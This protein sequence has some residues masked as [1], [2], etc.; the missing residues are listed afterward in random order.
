MWRGQASHPGGV[1]NAS[2]CFMLQKP[3]KALASGSV[4]CLWLECISPPSTNPTTTTD[5]SILIITTPPPLD[6]IFLRGYKAWGGGGGTPYNRLYREPLPERGSLFSLE[7]YK[8]VTCNQALFFQ[9][10]VGGRKGK[11]MPDTFI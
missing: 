9:A 2:F 4:G 5:H 7:V 6:D 11:S 1:V 10:E 3:G 8:R